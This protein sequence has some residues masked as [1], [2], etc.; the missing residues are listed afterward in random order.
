MALDILAVPVLGPILWARSAGEDVASRFLRAMGGTISIYGH[1]VIPAGFERIGDQQ[2]VVSTSFGVF[3]SNK[4]Y[5]DL[6][7]STRYETVH[8]LRLGAEIRPLY[9]E[10]TNDFEK[11]TG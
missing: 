3:D 8:E 4:V 5:L 2:M 1:D 10:K 7:L 9:P 11:I 6:D